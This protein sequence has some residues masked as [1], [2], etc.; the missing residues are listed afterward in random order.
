MEKY[1][2][3]T[4]GDDSYMF[5]IKGVHSIVKK[6]VGEIRS[7]PESPD[8]FLGLTQLREKTIGVISASKLFEK[9]VESTEEY[10]V[11]I[12]NGE[13]EDIYGITV[14]SVI[15]V[16][17]IEDVQ[18][19]ANNLLSSQVS[20]YIDKVYHEE[21]EIYL[22]LNLQKLLD[23]KNLKEITNDEKEEKG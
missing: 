9:K 5:N 16:K 11:I 13:D 4:V 6:K 18:D 23:F 20:K 14:D 15:G 22:I 17:N 19:I 12:V 8:Y 2:I 1:L 7:L 10:E 21:G 3:F